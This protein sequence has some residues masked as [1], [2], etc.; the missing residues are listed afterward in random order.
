[1]VEEEE[2]VVVEEEVVERRVA[3]WVGGLLPRV[4]RVRGAQAT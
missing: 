3:G 2:E 1:M 4:G